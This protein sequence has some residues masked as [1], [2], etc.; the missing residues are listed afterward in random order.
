MTGGTLLAVLIT[1]YLITRVL[2]SAI[3]FI[4]TLEDPEHGPDGDAAMVAMIPLLGEIVVAANVVTGILS[5]LRD[6]RGT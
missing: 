2:G 3:W 5:W 4:L 6:Q 1:Y